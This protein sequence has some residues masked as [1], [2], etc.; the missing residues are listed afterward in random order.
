[1]G[2]LRLPFRSIFG[3]STSNRVQPSHQEPGDDAH[4]RLELAASAAVAAVSVLSEA[5]WEEIDQKN[6]HLR[7][8]AYG[9]IALAY[10]ASCQ[11]KKEV[12]LAC[13][14]W[15][16]ARKTAQPVAQRRAA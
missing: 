7:R 1:V 10:H 11:L 3:V 5:Y 8:H 13:S 6:E 4:D 2:C 9:L 15:L 14:E 16:Q 12:S